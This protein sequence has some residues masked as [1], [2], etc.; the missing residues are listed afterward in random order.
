MCFAIT[1]VVFLPV[2]VSVIYIKF[3]E[4]TTVRYV[5]NRL[6]GHIGGKT[7]LIFFHNEKKLFDVGDSMSGFYQ[8]LETFAGKADFFDKGDSRDDL[9]QE[10]HR[11]SKNIFRR[12]NY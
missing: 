4:I 10:F 1:T 12:G 7:Q 5:E 2:L 9:Y 11:Q 8:L 6:M 3:C